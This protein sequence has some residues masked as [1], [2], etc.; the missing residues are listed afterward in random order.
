MMFPIGNIVNMES[1]NMGTLADRLREERTR[2]ALTQ[3]QMAAA[4]GLNRTAQIRYEKGERNPDADYLAAVAS[5]GVDIGYVVTGVTTAALGKDEV[6]LLRRY[7]ATT[8]EVRAAVL[9][10][11][12][13]VA[14]S[15]SG[16][17]QIGNASQ[18]IT[19]GD[20]NQSNAQFHI[21]AGKKK[22]TPGK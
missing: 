11:L 7:R 13:I 2:L 22:R 19:G 21:S 18:I 20:V 4:A 1:S 10:A 12:G 17:V 6:E 16:G 15:T 9:G 8:P 14:V 3:D 5:V